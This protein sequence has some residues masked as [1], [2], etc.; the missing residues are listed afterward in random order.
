M[1]GQ[2]CGMCV[3]LLIL[4]PGGSGAN[5]KAE[6]SSETAVETPHDAM[7]CLELSLRAGT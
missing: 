4:L 3:S 5:P 2:T 7:C 1:D 6:I